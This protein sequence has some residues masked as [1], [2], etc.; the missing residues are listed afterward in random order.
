MAKAYTAT[1]INK[2]ATLAEGAW[3]HSEFEKHQS[4]A[5]YQAVQAP[6]SAASCPELLS[7]LDEHRGHPPSTAAGSTN[8]LDRRVGRERTCSG[9][10]RQ[11]EKEAEAAQGCTEPL[12]FRFQQ[13]QAM[14]SSGESRQGPDHSP[15]EPEAS[16]CALSLGA[17]GMPLSAGFRVRRWGCRGDEM[18]PTCSL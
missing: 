8:M 4:E 2:C 16:T 18:H 9:R 15:T 11:T 1:K 14:E 5:S 3:V 13:R 12:V 17:Q 6:G 7:A 10:G